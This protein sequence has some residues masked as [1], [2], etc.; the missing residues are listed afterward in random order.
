VRAWFLPVHKGVGLMV[1]GIA[2]AQ[3]LGGQWAR[4]E[5]YQLAV[6]NT[7]RFG[8]ASIGYNE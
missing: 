4:S 7:D 5:I 2:S 3:A 8:G 6:F 1:F